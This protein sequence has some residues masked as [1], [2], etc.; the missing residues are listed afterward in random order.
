LDSTEIQSLAV[1][2]LEYGR[3]NSRVPTGLG[4]ENALCLRL[5]QDLGES[6]RLGATF[7]Q[8]QAAYG[9]GV[10]G[11]PA[12]RQTMGV[13]LDSHFDFH[14]PNLGLALEAGGTTGDRA[15]SGAVVPANDRFYYA[16]AV[17]P[18][19]GRLSLSYD[20]VLA[21]YDFDGDL[22]KDGG[23]SLYQSLSGGLALDGLG[24][25]KLLETLPLYDHSLGKNLAFNWGFSLRQ[26]RDQLPDP[27]SGAL[28]PSDQSTEMELAF[29]N[30]D[31]AHPH[32]EL[33]DIYE[34]SEDPWTSSPV[35][36]QSLNLRLP[37]AEK[38]FL[39]L[40]GSLEWDRS[41][42]KTSGESGETWVEGGGFGLEWTSASKLTL[43][44][45]GSLNASH[46][47][48]QGVWDAG[49]VHSKFSASL[50]QVFSANSL[51]RLDYGQPAL[52]GR[53]FGLQD[54]INLFTLTAKTYF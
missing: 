26:S 5:R 31:T 52:F 54:T 37:L 15:P 29:E 43:A 24:P 49:Q 38:F 1:S 25:A 22:S 9:A 11:I 39:N 6:L 7:L 8:H 28:V 17:N 42:D 48:W 41:R 13:D 46:G 3:F 53:D 27:S 44:A 19:W 4:P 36:R 23:N 35:S 10:S 45:G 18:A 32:F 40:G 2:R 34:G 50:T 16:A 51:V 12:S 14:G 21:G 20:F 33:Q 47:S 30:D